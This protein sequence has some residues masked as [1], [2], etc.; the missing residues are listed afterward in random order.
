[1]LTYQVRPRVFRIAEGQNLPFPADGEVRFYLAPLQPFGLEA[2]GGRTAV[3]AVA[4]SVL[5]NANTGAHTVESQTPLQPLDLTIEE[6]NRI[7]RVQGNILTVS[8]SFGSNRELTEVVEGI[9]FGIPV[10]LAV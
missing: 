1:M 5:F 2:G 4:A 3:R 8:Q 10:L 7:I 9:Y 6:P